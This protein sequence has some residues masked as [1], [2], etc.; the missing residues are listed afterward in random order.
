MAAAVGSVLLILSA[1]VVVMSSFL[2]ILMIWW[3]MNIFVK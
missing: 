2:H 1:D 3:V